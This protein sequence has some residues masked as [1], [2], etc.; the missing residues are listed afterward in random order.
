MI[1]DP[2]KMGHGWQGIA[3]PIQDGPDLRGVTGFEKNF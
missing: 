1:F 2:F 3:L